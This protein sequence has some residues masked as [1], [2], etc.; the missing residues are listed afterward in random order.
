M[1]KFRV[2]LIL[3]NNLELCNNVIPGGKRPPSAPNRPPSEPDRK[4]IDM[5]SPPSPPSPFA[6]APE[7]IEIIRSAA[8]P[9]APAARPKFYE[10]VD[11]ELGNVRDLGPG[12]VART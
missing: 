1:D 5:P 10:L 3:F 4:E 7:L 11:R 9:I 8:L 2:E 6:D 12:L